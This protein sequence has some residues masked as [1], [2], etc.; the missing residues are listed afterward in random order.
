M[1]VGSGA[2]GDRCRAEPAGHRTG[3]AVPPLPVLPCAAADRPRGRTGGRQRGRPFVSSAFPVCSRASRVAQRIRSGN[4]T[5]SHNRCWRWCDLVRAPVSRRST[6]D[7]L[8]SPKRRRH[9]GHP[10]LLDAGHRPSGCQWWTPPIYVVRAC[11]SVGGGFD[12]SG[13]WP[14]HWY[15][16]LTICHFRIAPRRRPVQL[17]APPTPMWSATGRGW[18]NI[19]WA[20][21]RPFSMV[22]DC[23]LK[24]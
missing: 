9:V 4:Y 11:A 10:V 13:Q 12:V 7:L 8:T 6:P 16:D 17:S 3:A 20:I 1:P 5:V 23:C 2:S 15:R 22:S 19:G 21:S 18:G 24:T 14:G